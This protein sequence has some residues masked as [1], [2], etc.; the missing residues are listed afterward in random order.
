MRLPSSSSFFPLIFA[1]VIAL[2]GPLSGAQVHSTKEAPAGPAE[3]KRQ[4]EESRRFFYVNIASGADWP[5]G[6]MNVIFDPSF[7][8]LVRVEHARSPLIRAGVQLSFHSFAAERPGTRDNGGI[9]NLSVYGKALGVWGPYRPFGL[10]GV[11]GYSS[12]EED[13]SRRLDGGFQMGGGLE[14][15]IT[16]H[17]SVTAATGLHV[18][19]RGDQLDDLLWFDGHIGFLFREP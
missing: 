12:K 9:V 4:D 19:F 2:P 10:F 16:Q 6:E 8:F 13:S 1:L 17:L 7:L 5:A 15:P 3:E 11:G 14:L 18:V